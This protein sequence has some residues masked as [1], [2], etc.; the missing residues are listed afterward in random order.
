MV[1]AVFIEDLMGV[2]FSSTMSLVVDGDFVVVIIG[3]VF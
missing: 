3:V 2:V 1:G